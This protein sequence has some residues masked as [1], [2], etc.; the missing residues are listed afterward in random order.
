MSVNPNHCTIKFPVIKG[1]GDY[2]QFS[3]DARILSQFTKKNVKYIELKP[4]Y[5]PQN[6]DLSSYVAVFFI[7]KTPEVEQIIENDKKG[8]LL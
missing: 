8:L 4:V 6:D 7:E 2:H 5:S 3:R 1:A